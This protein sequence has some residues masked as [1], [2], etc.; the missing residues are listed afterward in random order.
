MISSGSFARDSD[1]PGIRCRRRLKANRKYRDVIGTRRLSM[2]QMPWP[3][4]SKAA[5]ELWVTAALATFRSFCAS[6]TFSI[7]HLHH[8]C[9]CPVLPDH[10]KL[11]SLQCFKKRKKTIANPFDYL[12]RVQKKIANFSMWSR[13]ASP[14]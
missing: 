9:T 14:F 11:T 6:L 1:P 5:A 2:A 3:I 7:E 13:R 12:L 8:L 4:R 10:L